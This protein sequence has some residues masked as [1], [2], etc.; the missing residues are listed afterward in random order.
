[1]SAHPSVEWIEKAEGNYD[2]ARVLM[3]QR[4]HLVPDVVCN[5]CQQCA[6]KYLKALLVRHGLSFPKTHDLTQLKNLIKS[7]D[8]DILLIAPALETLNPYGI[9]VRYPGLQAT[10]GD[11][12]E[13]VV[14]MKAVRKF[15]RAKLGL[16]P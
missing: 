9:D 16:K 15:A 13:A 6:E 10:A 3:R 5:Q 1:M 2:S 8:A 14:A 4:K 12:R 7:I 11:A